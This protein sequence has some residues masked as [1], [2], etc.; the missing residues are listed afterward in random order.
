MGDFSFADLDRRLLGVVGVVLVGALVAGALAVAQLGLLTD[1]YAMSGVFSATG[2]LEA[3]AP[4]RVAGVQVGEVTGI[5]PDFRQ[6][7]VI[8]TWEVD[9]SVRLGPRTRANIEPG[10]LL[11]SIHL[12]LSGP[13]E[14][15]YVADRPPAERRVPAVRT[16]QSGTVVE[17]LQT[18]TRTLEDLDAELLNTAV[19]R[20]ADTAADSRDRLGSLLEHLQRAVSAVNQRDEQ[21]AE[22][23]SDSRTVTRALASR[24]AELRRLMDA[25]DTV[26]Q[27]IVTRRD[28]LAR[29]LGDGSAAVR[30][31]TRLIEDQRGELD[32][33]LG[34]LTTTLEVADRRL[35]ELNRTLAWIGPTFSGLAE[36]GRQGP[37]FDVVVE[38]LGPLAPE[39]LDPDQLSSVPA[40]TE[41]RRR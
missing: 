16:S 11:G 15:P 39:L 17:T 22:L 1:R 33:I 13:V 31:L 9:R 12:S 28:E 14:E 27:Q 30:R 40:V 35:P 10:T 5:R 6:G 8:I 34:D 38:Q 36:P 25:A 20:L 23:V 2:G 32:R 24:E 26:L 41:G 4:V 18:T 29:L 21:L 3:G 7:H 19:G 37:W